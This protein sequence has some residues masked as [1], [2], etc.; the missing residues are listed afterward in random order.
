MALTGQRVW[1][2]GLWGVAQFPA[3]G[4][5][6]MNASGEKAVAIIRVPKSGTLTRFEALISSVSNAPDNGLRFSFQD[7]DLST[8]QPDGVVDQSATVASGS[9]TAGW[10]NP[11][12]F[13]SSR[14]VTRG[15]YLACVL[16]YP[17]FTAGDNLNASSWQIAFNQLPYG[18]IDASSKSGNSLVCALLYDDG[19]YAYLPFFPGASVISTQGF[20]NATAAADEYGVAFTPD[21]PMT[22]SEVM[23]SLAIAAGAD[24]DLVL[25]DSSDNVLATLSHDGNVTFTSSQGLVRL[26]LGSAVDLTAG[27]LYRLTIK[28]T[29][30]NSVTIS[31]AQYPSSDIMRDTSDAG[32]DFYLTRRVDAGAWT[33]FNNVTDGFRQPFLSLGLSRLDN[34]AGAVAG[35]IF[36]G[37]VVR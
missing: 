37:Q 25:Y 21:V 14:S 24:F 7:V 5:M 30:A 23:L 4:A 2:P 32:T 26:P 11:G 20:N 10:L 36:G 13:G 8:G 29:T 22:V 3:F 1:V 19:T 12:N 31:Y 35:S 15:D 28:P 9:V 6:T 34:G 17:T 18:I 27:Q 33:D 16:D